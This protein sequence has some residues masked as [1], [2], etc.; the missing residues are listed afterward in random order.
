MAV[1][2]DFDLAIEFCKKECIPN[3]YGTIT[4]II[5]I[6]DYVSSC[7]DKA[8][9]PLYKDGIPPG[10]LQIAV[11]KLPFMIGERVISY[12]S[13]D[14]LKKCLLGSSAAFPL[15][16]LIYR[17]GYWLIDG[18][19]TDFQPVVDSDTLT[20]SPFYFS[21]A[22]IKPS[23]YVPLWWALLPPNSPDTV[24]WLYSLGWEDAMTYFDSIGIPATTPNLKSQMKKIDKSSHPYDIPKQVTIH[25]F[26]GYD[27]SK[28]ANY[29]LLFVLDFVLL[30]LFM[31]VF[32]P[33]ALLLI[34]LEL[35]INA[36]LYSF[37]LFVCGIYFSFSRKIMRI[38]QFGLFPN[39]LKA[40]EIYTSKIWNS[41]KSRVWES[42]LCISSLSL[43]LRF[44]SIRP[45]KRL[46]KKH[47]RLEK[48]SLFY[49][50]FRHI[51]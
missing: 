27:F 49:R 25:R 5:S 50:V 36:I 8:I 10:I 42:I 20:V 11:T 6:S 28:I 44:V 23:R 34:Y 16:R 31:F 37:L 14:D 1:G 4:G 3:T 29:Y 32:K 2:G 48:I 35:Y 19:I 40:Y 15:A 45:S 9:H 7:I 26:L 47:Q 21:D 38:L 24:D 18:G 46:L 17:K 12:D 33:T 13:F 39:S 43:F 41:H 30:M 22:D 51:V